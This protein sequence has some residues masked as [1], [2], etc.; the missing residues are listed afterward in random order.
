VVGAEVDRGPAEEQKQSE[1][2]KHHARIVA[3]VPAADEWQKRPSPT[4]CCHR[5]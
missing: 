4:R 2:E 1:D 5:W 3:P